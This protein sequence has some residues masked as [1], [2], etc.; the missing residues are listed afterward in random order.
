MPEGGS[1]THLARGVHIV[2]D[3]KPLFREDAAVAWRRTHA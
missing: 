2:I 3:A 1:D